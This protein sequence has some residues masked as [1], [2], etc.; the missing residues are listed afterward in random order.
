MH[1][2]NMFSTFLIVCAMAILTGC[3]SMPSPEAMKAEA[4]TFQLPKLP[5]TGKAIVYVV[6]PSGLGGLIRFNV[7]VDNQEAASE[8]G[9]TRGTQY[10]Y[11]NLVPGQHKIY[12]KAENWAETTILAKAG[13][14]IFIQQVTSMGF[15][16]AQNTIFKLED[17]LGKYHVKHLTVGTIIKSDK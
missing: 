9:Y 7:F 10:I 3:A 11:F 6:R 4:A 12:S 15:L 13:D 1:K 17:Y 2:N 8:M 14:I 16:M 5:E